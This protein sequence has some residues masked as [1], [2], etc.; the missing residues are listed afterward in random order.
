MASLAP[1]V[2]G[3]M[4][5][6]IAAPD[7]FLTSSVRGSPVDPS[8]SVAE[9]LVATLVVDAGQRCHLEVRSERPSS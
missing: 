2:A 9:A 7:G 1:S 3:K 4:D 5:V 8:V 6:D